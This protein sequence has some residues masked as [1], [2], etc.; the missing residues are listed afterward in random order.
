MKPHREMFT[1]SKVLGAR[2]RE[3][4][5]RTGMTAEAVAALMGRSGKGG[6]TILTRLEKG[7]KP[8]PTMQ[9]VADYLRAC[10]ATFAEIASVLDAYTK[11][12][13]LPAREA[14]VGVARMARELPL[15]VAAAVMRY[16]VKREAAVPTKR[17]GPAEA[18]KRLLRAR[19]YAWSVL[20]RKRLHNHI[21]T[22]IA[23]HHW[24]RGE[25]M[26]KYLQDYCLSVWAALERTRG[27][28]EAER[29][30]LLGTA[31]DA[32][33]RWG[34][35]DP[36]HVRVLG[37][38]TVD[39]FKAVEQSGELDVLPEVGEAETKKPSKREMERQMLAAHREQYGRHVA[40]RRKVMDKLWLQ[41]KAVLLAQG[42]EEARLG[43]YRNAVARSC[44]IAD[45]YEPGS[46]QAEKALWA[47]ANEPDF[48]KKGQDPAVVK[49]VADFVIPRYLELRPTIPPA[50]TAVSLS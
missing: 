25:L 2:L 43:I 39:M 8:S 9:L 32:K 10:R 36:E 17:P 16:D 6:D 18:A 22:T 19:R 46:E 40:A 28:G 35:S 5:K 31:R 23:E 7:K 45:H 14:Q 1:S 44:H 21:M 30:T 20:W 29:E 42:V 33:L 15:E 27:R 48:V 50:P 38:A 11:Q 12:P 4:R 37:Q 47:Y 24:G 3:M 13:T 41:V 34:V 26:K 49:L